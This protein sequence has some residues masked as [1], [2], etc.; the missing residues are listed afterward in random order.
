VKFA[1]DRDLLIRKIRDEAKKDKSILSEYG[2]TNAQEAF[3]ESH[4]AYWM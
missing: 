2:K 4:A 3:A 1:S